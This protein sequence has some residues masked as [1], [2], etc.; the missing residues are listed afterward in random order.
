MTTIKVAKVNR[1]SEAKKPVF[2]VGQKIRVKKTGALGK[3]ISSYRAPNGVWLTVE[4][5]DKKK[6]IPRNV[7]PS[8]VEKV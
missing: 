8:A 2:K 1:Q 7:R 6:S 3:V 4:F 5:G